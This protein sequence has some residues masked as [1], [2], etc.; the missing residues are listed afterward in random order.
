MDRKPIN[1]LYWNANGIRDQ[2]TELKVTVQ[3]H[4]VDVVLI[5]ETHLKQGKSLKLPNFVTYRHDRTTGPQGGTAILV[6]K[7]VPHYEV[8]PPPLNTVEATTVIAKVGGREMLLAAVYNRPSLQLDTSDITALLGMKSPAILAGDLNAKHPA[9]NSSVSNARGNELYRFATNNDVVV[10]APDEPT[11]FHRHGSDV[12]DVAILNEINSSYGLWSLPE[13]SSDHNPVLLTLVELECNVP[14]PNLH[15]CRTVDWSRFRD[16]VNACVDH[17]P[18]IETAQELDGCVERFCTAVRA[19]LDECT[20]S[21]RRP[22]PQYELPPEV[23]ELI[24]RKNRIRKI[25]QKYRNPADRES[26][27]ALAHQVREAVAKHRDAAWRDTVL[28]LTT[29][30]NSLWQ[31]TRRLTKTRQFTPALVDGNGTMVTEPEAKAELFADSLQK[32]FTANSS[33]LPAQHA[34]V[35]NFVERFL[36]KPVSSAAEPTT[37]SEVTAI[38]KSLNEKKAPGDDAIGNM[39]LKRLPESAVSSLVAIF[40]KIYTLGHFPESWKLAKVITIPKAGKPLKH[41]VNHR[42]I[43]LL[44]N[45]SKLFERTLQSRIVDHLVETDIIVDE[46]FGFRS[47]HS[48]TQQLLRLTES[49][50]RGFNEHRHT[51]AVFLDIE[52]AFDKVWHDGLL[53]KLIYTKLPDVY[54]QVIRSYLNNRSFY[55]S[56]EGAKSSIRPIE[57]GVPQGSVVGP[58]LFNVYVND[59]PKELETALYADDTAIFA[60][61][62]QPRVAHRKLQEHLQRLEDYYSMWRI[63]VNVQKSVAVMFSVRRISDPE[64]LT[65]FG[66]PIQWEPEAKYLGVIL[67]K[68]LTFVKHTDKQIGKAWGQFKKLY[69]LLNG[70]SMLS[71]DNK[72]LIY[73]SFVRPV[74]TY[75]STAW[76]YGGTNVRKMQ[77]FQNKVLRAIT[78]AHYLVRNA[79]LHQDLRIETIEKHIRAQALKLYE[80][81]EGHGNGLVSGL[82]NYDAENPHYRHKRPRLMIQQN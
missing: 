53:Y 45:V 42:P 60:Q 73:I 18:K 32:Q 25:W 22:P 26:L 66:S 80:K 27:T 35:S 82:G 9:W 54:I 4:K 68:R 38:I 47:E 43:S 52:K 36:R 65:L 56:S 48:T 58:I 2:A 24:S 34:H 13:L 62:W 81:A 31:C 29:E 21:K 69:P 17:D 1:L 67:D 64:P 70:R 10:V 55:V 77:V 23:H 3:K 78:G 5:C 12:L 72:R 41:A 79:T 39:A 7:S 37:F 15:H 16:K 61:S 8:V 30:D 40:N 63:K 28:S 75:A 74:L 20:S 19:C 33:E 59:I 49:V 71:L 46:Q 51:G 11:H 76:A 57:A 44:S 14:V 50:T 6:K